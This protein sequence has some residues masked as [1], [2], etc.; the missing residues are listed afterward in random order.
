M[1]NDEFLMT[2]QVPMTKSGKWSS[3]LVLKWSSEGQKKSR[4]QTS[5][6]QI[7]RGRAGSRLRPSLARTLAATG[8]RHGKDANHVAERR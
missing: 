6:L 5:E 3:A 8:V 7:D 4:E 2:N 1:T